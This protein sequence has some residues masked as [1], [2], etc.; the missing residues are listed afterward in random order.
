MTHADSALP[1]HARGYEGFEGRIG[2]TAADSTPAW[3]TATTPALGSPNIVVVLIDDMGYSD[4]GPF[5]SEIETPTL[6]RLASQGIRMTNYH[7]TPLCSPSR[8]ALLTG[9]NPHRAGY[10][11]VANADPGYPGLRLE[12]ADDVQ[13]LPEILRG[14]GYATYA[15][16]KWH[17]VR[18]A[19]LAPGRSRDS[20]PTQRGFDR[21]YGSLEG[22]NSFYYPN[23]L[24]SDNSVV[25]VDEYP[26][27]TTS[28]TI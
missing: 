28:P 13:T 12:L 5:G 1:P 6:D 14:A 27:A 16:G 21:Y 7:T 24:I 9:L 26:E 2:R 17:L 20:W 4:I 10:G 15:V 11:F 18:D 8:A 25:D 23:Q 3:P 22:L 19:N